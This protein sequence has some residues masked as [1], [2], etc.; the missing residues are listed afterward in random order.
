VYR[1]NK[2]KNNIRNKSIRVFGNAKGL[3]I[4]WVVKRLSQ[5]DDGIGEEKKTKVAM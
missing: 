5:H 1:K 4:T 2:N 3:L